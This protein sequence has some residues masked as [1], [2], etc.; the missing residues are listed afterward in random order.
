MMT[1]RRSFLKRAGT[2]ASVCAL[3]GFS[4]RSILANAS[5]VNERQFE[6]VS[7]DRTT[8]KLEYRETPRRSMDREL[9]HW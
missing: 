5:V 6:V 4:R 1:N 2:L 7:V 9:P 3:T 8:V